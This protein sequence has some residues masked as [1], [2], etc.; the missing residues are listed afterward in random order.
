M[1]HL[2]AS[3]PTGKRLAMSIGTASNA[4]VK[5]LAFFAICYQVNAAHGGL[6][7]DHLKEFETKI[8]GFADTED[9]VE[10]LCALRGVGRKTG[11][12]AGSYSAHPGFICMNIDVHAGTHFY[13]YYK[14]VLYIYVLKKNL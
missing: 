2:L 8:N 9:R 7:P 1:P 10:F 5:V 3:T 13:R 4:S 6:G 11:E 14:L 12:C